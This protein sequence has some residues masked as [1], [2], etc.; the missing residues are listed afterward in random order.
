MTEL[1][2]ERE[3]A[4]RLQLRLDPPQQP[5]HVWLILPE[6]TELST[7]VHTLWRGGGPKGPKG[8]KPKMIQHSE[9]STDKEKS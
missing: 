8:P 1:R 4:V 7:V 9:E 5:G 3:A 6:S 2:V